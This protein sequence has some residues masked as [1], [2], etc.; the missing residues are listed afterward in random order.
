[1]ERFRIAGDS[2]KVTTPP[3]HVCELFINNALDMSSEIVSSAAA[4]VRLC[5]WDRF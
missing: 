4:A 3:E 5:F 1:L 2:P